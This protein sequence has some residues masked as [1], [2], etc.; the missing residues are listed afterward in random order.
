[1]LRNTSRAGI[2]PQN[3]D[4]HVIAKYH[5][6]TGAFNAQTTA[7]E[8]SNFPGSSIRVSDEI[9]WF[10]LAKEPTPTEFHHQV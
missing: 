5:Y 10:H 6:R 2:I 9:F 4:P 1:M 7:P 3:P 8:V